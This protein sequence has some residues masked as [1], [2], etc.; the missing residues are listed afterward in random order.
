M[1]VDGSDGGAEALGV[2]AATLAVVVQPSRDQSSALRGAVP[3][4][5]YSVAE[6]GESDVG[7]SPDP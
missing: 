1:T 2:G 7:M 5:K 6:N 3:L 4:T